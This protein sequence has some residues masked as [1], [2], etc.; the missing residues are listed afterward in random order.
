MSDQ[1]GM[2]N[3]AR[4]KNETDAQFKKRALDEFTAELFTNPQFQVRLKQLPAPS[5]SK[6][7]SAWDWIVRV[8]ANMLGLKTRAQE[9]ALDRALSVGAALLQENA[10]WPESLQRTMLRRAEWREIHCSS[11]YAKS[12]HSP[13]EKAAKWREIQPRATLLRPRSSRHAAEAGHQDADGRRRRAAGAEQQREADSL[14]RG[15]G[16]ELLAVVW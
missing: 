15:G 6:L 10:V 5:G 13:A 3:F 4:F 2:G 12:N 8:I 9:T 11:A 1:Y 16:S 14:E 7:K